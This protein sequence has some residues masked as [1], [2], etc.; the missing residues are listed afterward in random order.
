MAWKIRIFGGDAVGQKAQGGHSRVEPFRWPDLLSSR[1]P[2]GNSQTAGQPT[3][4]FMAR[5][6]RHQKIGT[7][8]NSPAGKQETQEHRK[9]SK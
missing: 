7:Q 9:T 4:D 1:D 2:W 6:S 3:T 8:G 5:R